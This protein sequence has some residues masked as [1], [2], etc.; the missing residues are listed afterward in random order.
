MLAGNSKIGESFYVLK[1]GNNIYK[2]LICCCKLVYGFQQLAGEHHC[3]VCGITECFQMHEW[4]FY[5]L[6]APTKARR[7]RAELMVLRDG[8]KGGYDFVN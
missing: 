6:S 8:L 5:Y 7:L 4:E 3:G 1:T 2:L